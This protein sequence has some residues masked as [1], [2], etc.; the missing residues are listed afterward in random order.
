MDVGC[1]VGWLLGPCDIFVVGIEV[2]CDDGCDVGQIIGI[3]VGL[4]VG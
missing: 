1:V 4:V 2:G 3:P